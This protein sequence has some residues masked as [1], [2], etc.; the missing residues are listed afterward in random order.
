[1]KEARVYLS[2]GVKHPPHTEDFRRRGGFRDCFPAPG[3]RV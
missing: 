1:M 2:S 3:A